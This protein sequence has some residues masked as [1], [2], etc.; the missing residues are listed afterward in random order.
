MVVE[1]FPITDSFEPRC[2]VGALAFSHTV[3]VAHTAGDRNRL[4]SYCCRSRVLTNH[5]FILLAECIP[6]V[7]IA[8]RRFAFWPNLP[9]IGVARI[10]WDDIFEPV[11]HD[12]FGPVRVGYQ[13][14]S[15]SNEIGLPLFQ[16]GLRHLGGVDTPYGHD[17]YG[18]VL[19]DG[20][21]QVCKGTHPGPLGGGGA[22]FWVITQGDIEEIHAGL[23]QFRGEYLALSQGDTAGAFFFC[24][25]AYRTAKP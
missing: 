16:D 18:H 20:L 21:R 7:T 4:L 22:S 12:L 24:T 14:P 5:R 19:F 2:V 3:I 1:F 10:A 13:L 9:A 15:D 23:F 17:G 6:L 25:A 11:F 8:F